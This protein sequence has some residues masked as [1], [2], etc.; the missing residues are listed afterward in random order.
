MLKEREQI[1]FNVI[2][3][4]LGTGWKES[5]LIASATGISYSLKE[6]MGEKIAPG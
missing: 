2:E 3:I 5:P 1:T 4:L 6:R